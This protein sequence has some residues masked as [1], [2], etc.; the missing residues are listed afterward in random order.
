MINVKL[1]HA[2]QP[3][4]RIG[5]ANIYTRG[6]TLWVY[7]YVDGVKERYSLKK[8]DNKTNRAWAEKNK[9]K[10]FYEL[11]SKKKPPI[12][13]I[14][15]R[16]YGLYVLEIT[17]K[18]RSS[19][20]QK[21]NLRHFKKVCEY[22]GDMRL[23]TIKASDIQKWQN[24]LSYAPKT[25]RNYRGTLNIILEMAYQDEIINRNPLKSVRAPKKP[26][27]IP[28]SYSED[29]VKK[30][31]ENSQGQMK[32]ILQFAFFSGV[33]PSELIALKWSDINFNAD[34]IKIERR[35]RDGNIDMPKGYK[36]RIIDLLPQAKKALK[37]QQL[38]TGLGEWVWLSQLG[39]AYRTPKKINEG[40]KKICIKAG[41]RHALFYD[42]TKNTFCTLMLEY[43]QSESWLIQQVGH[44]NINV[45]RAHYIGKIKPDFSKLKGIAV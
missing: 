23:A 12:D 37:N 15:L 2:D 31:L 40:F 33:R 36:A 34:S 32:N 22:F 9:E 17:S 10:L 18:N 43:G 24:S 21:E 29:E 25:V 3:I 7:A 4:Q 26:R 41:V 5:M 8:K 16:E 35:I 13:K 27:T 28:F 6:N 19:F 11:H 45:T 39:V 42:A 20:T 1:L 14:T 38:L 44:E 30:I